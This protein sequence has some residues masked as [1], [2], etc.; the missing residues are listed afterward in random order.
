[1]RP[2]PA[3]NAIPST[4]WASR[5][6]PPTTC[7]RGTTSTPAASTSPATPAAPD[8]PRISSAATRTSSA[9]CSASTAAA[10]TCRAAAATTRSHSRR[11]AG[12]APTCPSKQARSVMRIVLLRGERDAYSRT[13]KTDYASFKLDG[14]EHVS[15]F[16]IPGVGHT[17]P[18]EGTWLSKGLAALDAEPAQG[19][20]PADDHAARAFDEGEVRQPAPPAAFAR[21]R[22]TGR[23]RARQRQVVGRQRHARGGRHRRRAGAEGLSRHAGRR[24]RQG[25]AGPA[26]AR[27][28]R[29]RAVRGRPRRAR[30]SGRCS[31]PA[32]PSSA[33]ATTPPGS[34]SSA[35]SR[36][37]RTPRKPARPRRGSNG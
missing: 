10:S 30:R 5:S 33:T 31:P 12:S 37:R 21:P 16:E 28:V 27:Q 19:A 20:R 36:S 2:T 13:Q 29:R 18:R 25:A 9:A 14:F 22:R 17:F 26:R 6:T 1:M 4:A 7:G 11:S 32:R 24:R 35:S 34:T 3:T 23:A 15:Y 8:A